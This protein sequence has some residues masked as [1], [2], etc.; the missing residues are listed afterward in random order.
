MPKSN[1]LKSLEELDQPDIYSLLL[2]SIYKLYD[3]KE[4]S[5]L[6]ELVYVLDKTNLYNFL[7]MYGGM[8]IKVPKLT[9]LQKMLDALL[10]YQ[11]VNFEGKDAK[12]ALKDF[13]HIT[14]PQKELLEMYKVL[15]DVLSEY[16]FKIKR[17]EEDESVV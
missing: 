10:L 6:S 4:Y 16:D 1:I 14:Y 2:F 15:K 8:T 9:D 5:T 17:T 13:T 3:D 11:Q 7:S 12:D